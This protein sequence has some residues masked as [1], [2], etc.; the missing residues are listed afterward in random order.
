MRLHVRPGSS[1]LLLP[2]VLAAAALAAAGCGGGADAAGTITIT[3]LSADAAHVTGGDVLVSITA[4]DASRGSL[5]VSVGGRDVTAAFQEDGE[6]G[7][8]VGLVTGLADGANTLTARAGGVE[9]TLDLTNYPI[10]GPVFS[11]ARQTPF[12]CQTQDFSLPDGSTLGPAL[13]GNCSVK[14]VVQYVYRTKGD[15][16]EWKPLASR[17]A[18]P[19]D[20]AETTTT[21]GITVPFVVRVETGSMDR[22]IY[23]NTILHDPT[24]EPEPTPIAA[25]RGWNHRL[26]GVH[27]SGCPGG[28]YI[29]G[30]RMGVS[31]LDADRL[32]EGY[33]VFVNTLNHP[34]NSCNAVVAGEAAMM[35]KEHFIEEFGVPFYTFSTGGSGGA[36]TSLQ[37]AD[38]YPGLFDGVSIRATFPDAL[39]IAMA[40][41]DAH[42]FTHYVATHPGAF[43]DAQQ[44][45]VTGYQGVP[46]MIDAANQAQRTDPVPDRK[47][48]KGYASA[49]WNDAVPAGLRY[50]PKANPSGARPTI[51]D[52]ARNVYGVDPGTGA[53][54]RTFDNVGVQYGLDALNGGAITL[55]QFLDLNAGIGG[56][57]GDANYIAARSSADAGTLRRTY[58]AGL[59]LGANGGLKDIPIFDNATSRETGGYHYGWFHFALRERVRQAN[60]GNSD[61]M[62]MWRSVDQDAAT[63]LFDD[64]MAA[65][66]ADTSDLP[67]REKVIR[68]KP[69]NG[70]D[71]CYDSQDKTTFIAD[72]LPFTSGPASPCS[73]QYPVYSNTR[74]EAGGPLAANVLKCQLKPIDFTDYT[75]SV[76]ADDVARLRQIFPGG[77]CDWTKPGV[78]QTPVV[79]WASF[80]PSPA[81]LIVDTTRN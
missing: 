38:A 24:R 7:P 74:K 47:D 63:K 56:L 22:G 12:I 75:V 51:F 3:P 60:G 69:A 25:P 14:T 15:K 54:R 11:G 8:L 45:A 70:V 57:D 10:E 72:A 67:Q 18:L 4:P 9:S 31:P 30:G 68:H 58:Q 77:V 66:K 79:P 53:A 59:M 65:Y 76:P 61:N 21:D 35:G 81:N 28:W 6:D 41:T 73:T 19:D 50:D 36:Y 46:A 78:E 5:A 48:I 52:A 23:Q 37:L 43:T 27:G 20:V 32:G 49:R 17:T 1:G 55:K 42:L 29:Q 64:W 33:A 13:D 80:G 16:P 39:D 2:T 34:T 62:V 26:M 71:G 40:G 44:I